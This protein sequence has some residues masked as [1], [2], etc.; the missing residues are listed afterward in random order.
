MYNS[1]KAVFIDVNLLV[2]FGHGMFTQATI[3]SVRETPP[4]ANVAAS[5][6][7]D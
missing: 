4:G 7:A 2:D 1:K 5:I 6:S 3:V